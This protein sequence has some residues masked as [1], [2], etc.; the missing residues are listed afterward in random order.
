MNWSKTKSIFIIAFLILNVFLGYQLLEKRAGKL[1]IANV[2]ENSV[3]DLLSLWNIE[4]HTELSHDQPELAQ[5]SAQFITHLDQFQLGDGQQLT[6]DEHR[7]VANLHSPVRYTDEEEIQVF[8]EEHLQHYV[9]NGEQYRFDRQTDKEFI[10]LQQV[11]EYPVFVGRLIFNRQEQWIDG[12]TQVYYHVVNSGTPQQ[13]ISSFSSIRSL[14]DNQLIAPDST[15]RHV[16]LGY[17][18]QV[19]EVEIQVLTPV[20]RVVVEEQAVEE[21]NVIKV[22]YVNAITGAIETE[23]IR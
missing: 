5:L 23:H 1:E 17:Y 6:I 9:L 7:L 8:Y 12:Y 2:T 4:I 15:V 21:Q 3:E 19:Y 10:L 14:L 11:N 20:W 13:V 18:G 16:Q 22:F